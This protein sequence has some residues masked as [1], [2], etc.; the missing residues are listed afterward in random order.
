M[1]YLACLKWILMFMTSH[2]QQ[3]YQRE[4]TIIATAEEMLLESTAGD[5]TLDELAH[6]LDIAKGT[7]Y[8]HFDSKDELFLQILIRYERILYEQTLIDDSPASVLVRMLV[9]ILHRPRRAMLFNQLEEKLADSHGLNRK[10]DELYDIRQKRMNRLLLVAKS[11][12]AE[13]NSCMT[14]RDYLSSIWA[15][16]QGGASLLNS[17]FYQRFLG[18]RD[19]LILSLVYQ[20]LDLPSLYRKTDRKTQLGESLDA[21]NNTQNATP[22]LDNQYARTPKTQ[23][24]LK[25]KFSPFGNMTPP[26]L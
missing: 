14:T 15:I 18:R 10:F 3:F 16:G 12:L 22:N 8:K 23:D 21:S 2:K 9:Q 24:K 5:L 20:V 13:Q 1:A 17:T 11:Y 7:L 4:K 26:A 19:T 25:D 6:T